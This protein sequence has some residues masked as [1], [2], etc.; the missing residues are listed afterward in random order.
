MKIL[1]SIL[2]LLITSSSYGQKITNATS[3]EWAGGRPQSGHGTYYK[4]ELVSKKSSTKIQFDQLWIGEKYFDI[5]PTN[6]Q[7][8][9]NDTIFAKK[10]TLYI[11][12]NDKIIPKEYRKPQKNIKKDIPV[13][14]KYKGKALLG[15]VL[16]NGKRK[17]IEIEKF[18]ILEK[19]RYQ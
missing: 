1:T 5:K 7:K 19:Q 13:P 2:I 9:L 18:K 6:S 17:Y 3:Q 15:Y 10:D 11:R 4:I 14:Y 12:V 16:K 8:S